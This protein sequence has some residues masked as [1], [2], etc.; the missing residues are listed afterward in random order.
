MLNNVHIQEIKTVH[1]GTFIGNI[2][3][4]RKDGFKNYST[5]II[6]YYYYYMYLSLIQL[7]KKLYL[8]SSK[9]EN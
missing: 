2:T 1:S 3:F 6:F 7:Q 4:F 8:R 9:V 5:I